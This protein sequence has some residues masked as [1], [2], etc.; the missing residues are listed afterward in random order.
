MLGVRHAV[1]H[2]ETP[3][4]ILLSAGRGGA[5]SVQS[6]AAEG[7][8]A[9]DRFDEISARARSLVAA[10]QG[11]QLMLLPG[12]WYVITAESFIDR[13]TEVPDTIALAPQVR[14]PILAIRGEKEDSRRYPAEEFQRHATAPCEA[15]VI[16]NS[17]H[18]YNGSEEKVT[19][20]VL[21]WL[22]R[23]LN[24]G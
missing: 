5:A 4:L 6:G 24:L 7:L 12:W 19:E 10:G 11:R 16:P 8:L 18:F 14:C 23:T 22:K 20:A 2:P 13:L 21:S 15:A 9:G 17:D 1:D 3:A